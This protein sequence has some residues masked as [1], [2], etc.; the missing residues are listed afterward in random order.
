MTVGEGGLGDGD[1][2]EIRVV[3]RGQHRE[4]GAAV[5]GV[6]ARGQTL[7]TC[8]DVGCCVVKGESGRDQAQHLGDG[9]TGVES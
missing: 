2:G 6:A 8:I 9:G 5:R 4:R 1:P 3:Q 7:G